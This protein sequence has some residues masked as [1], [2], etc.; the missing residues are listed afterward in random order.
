M[1]PRHPRQ[2][3]VGERGDARFAATTGPGPGV[4]YLLDVRGRLRGWRAASC[5][6]VSPGEHAFDRL[7][8]I[9]AQQNG[10][11]LVS[12]WRRARW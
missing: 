11:P 1:P 10:Y 2:W 4:P 3:K 5:P 12:R 8:T 7:V 6:A 9:A